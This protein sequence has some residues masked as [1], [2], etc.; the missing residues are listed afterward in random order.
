MIRRLLSRLLPVARPASLPQ[1]V[2]DAD[3]LAAWPG[4][5]SAV[6]VHEGIAH[7]D[8]EKAMEWLDTLQP[9]QRPLAWTAC[10]RAWLLNV[11]AALGERYRVFESA[12]ALLLSNQDDRLAQVTLNYLETTFRRIGR[13]LGDFVPVPEMGKEVLLILEDHD[14]YYRYVDAFQDPEDSP[15]SAGMCINQGCVHFVT[16]DIDLQMMEPVIVHEMT[17]SFLSG[18]PIPAWLN[19]G[20]AVNMERV[21]AG[22]GNAMLERELVLRHRLFW[23]AG[24]IQSFWNGRAYLQRTEA[25]ELAYDL[26][27]CL[28]T[29]LSSDWPRFMRFVTQAS[30]DDAGKQSAQ[31][32][33]DA[34]LGEWVRLFVGG[35][36]AGWAPD[37]SR[38]DGKPERGRFRQHLSVE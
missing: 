7:P 29:A 37:P 4:L 22:A 6:R 34:D 32:H 9:A 12:N 20:M 38:W 24:N 11:A 25:A 13:L 18:L 8:W 33:L 30:W 1:Q 36:G 28:V 19:E 23:T 35:D 16:Y 14:T 26:A 17:H 5:Q 10:E 15:I 21:F 27:R 31:N 2:S 3:T